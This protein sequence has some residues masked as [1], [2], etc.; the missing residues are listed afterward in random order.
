MRI[1]DL[2]AGIGGFSE[3]ARR[4][5][6]STAGICENDKYAVK[7]YNKN[8]GTN[9]TP[10]DIRELDTSKLPDFDLLTAGFPCQAFSLAGKRE[11]FDDSRGNIFFE[12]I[13]ILRDKRP[14]Y[15]L[16]E[17]VKG[18]LSH[19]SGRTFG[20]ILLCLGELG[21][22]CEWQVL[23]GKHFGVPQN[24]ERVF[25]I[26]YFRGESRLKVFPFRKNAQ[27]AVE[28]HEQNANTLTARYNEG[29]ANGTYIVE[30]QPEEQRIMQHS[31][32]G[33]ETKYNLRTIAGTVTSA[34][35]STGNTSN[36]VIDAYNSSVVD[37]LGAVRQNMSNSGPLVMSLQPRS[38]NRPTSQD[39]HGIF[40]GVK[41]R[42]LTLLEC[43]R[44]QSFKDGWTE[45]VSDSQQYR[46]LGNSI[47]VNVAE[48]I[49]RRW[50]DG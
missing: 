41:I 26:G 8:F 16:L 33:K 29:Q 19:D 7:I 10:T 39:Q 4:V 43:E 5:G 2:F 32:R 9:H 20:R 34:N 22:A 38:P 30:N 21:Y 27:E 44:L 49:F 31:R 42:R 12:V 1:Y 28:L 45:G 18:L 17:N 46:L 37:C 15:F 14:K 3:A 48:E 40:D 50:K 36:F 11:G 6:W 24:R 25:V 13:R 35:S 23:N 47:T